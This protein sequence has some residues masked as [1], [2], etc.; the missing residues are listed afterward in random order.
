MTSR[1]VA[2]FVGVVVSSSGSS[3]AQSPGPAGGLLSGV[4][5]GD[6]GTALEGATITAVLVTAGSKS[7]IIGKRRSR[8]ERERR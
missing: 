1:I 3:V 7:R 6:D 2:V 5:S 8:T 4:V